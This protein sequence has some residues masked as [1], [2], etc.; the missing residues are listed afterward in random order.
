MNSHPQADPRW[1]EQAASVPIGSQPTPN[2]RPPIHKWCDYRAWKDETTRY[3]P[4]DAYI[5]QLSQRKP[6]I[7]I[8][9]G[10][11]LEPCEDAYMPQL[12]QRKPQIFIY[13]N[14]I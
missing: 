4:S 9:P 2:G 13:S 7:F 8:Y 14:S 12:S 11:L 1:V 10:R 3:S 6:R 5:R